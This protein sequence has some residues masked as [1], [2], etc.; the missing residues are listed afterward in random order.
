MPR[1]IERFDWYKQHT[2]KHQQFKDISRLVGLKKEKGHTISL[3]LPS[4]N[5]SSTIG[6]IIQVIRKKLM[7]DFP[8]VDEICVMDG[9]STDDTVQ[10]AEAAGVKVYRQ[11][12]VLRSAGRG[13]GKGD[14]LWKSLYV[15]TGDIIV[16]LDS[17][18]RNIHPRFVYGL[19]GP[20]L[21]YPHIQLVKGFYQRPIQSGLKRRRKTGG[22]RVTELVARP[23]LSLFYPELSAFIQPLSG[24]YAGRRQA[25]ESVPFFTGY[26]VEIGLL[27][28]M[29]NRFGMEALAQVDLVER[30][31]YNQTIAALGRMSFGVMQA[32]LLRL[33]EDGKVELKQDFGRYF[34]QVDYKNGEYF[35]DKRRIEVIQRPPIREVEEYR[36]KFG[37]GGG[38]P[39]LK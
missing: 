27:I 21:E 12:R 17:D 3:C 36:R 16:W 10:V 18:I 20:L 32:V 25:L 9:G 7:E 37:L 26:G 11:E 19:V 34:T 2:F 23:L 31:H 15:M 22:G 24:E 8:L 35:L 13:Q 5:E 14:A 29:R 39:G 28:D 33:Q 30:V 6:N 4:L 1:R 38:S